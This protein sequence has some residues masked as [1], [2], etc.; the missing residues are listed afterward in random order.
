MNRKR[1][2]DDI[3]VYTV[4]G[5]EISAIIIVLIVVGYRIDERFGT[6]PFITIIM[7]LAGMLGSFYRLI[8]FIKKK[9]DME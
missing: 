1:G 4:I 5:I 7:A 6:S 8:L 2:I 3:G 9:G